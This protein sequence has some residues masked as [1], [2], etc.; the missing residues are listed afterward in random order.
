VGSLV[1]LAARASSFGVVV[2]AVAASTV[3]C[4]DSD[5]KAASAPAPAA[6]DAA[7]SADIGTSAPAGGG[8]G[9]ASDDAGL[10]IINP[11]GSQGTELDAGA[12]VDL[13]AAPVGTCDQCGAARESACETPFAAC[14]DQAACSAVLDCVYVTE[15]CALDSSGAV[16]VR[17]C[18]EAACD[19][20]PSLELFFSA[21]TCAF[22]TELCLSDC[23]GYCSGLAALAAL[24][25]D[26][27]ESTGDELPAGTP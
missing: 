2:L 22:C 24:A 9:G 14:R 19:D 23:S 13:D 16:C 20:P 11:G 15:Q 6:T 12:L 5:G 21:E 1:R 10:L 3:T 26:C 4:V 8:A 18:V 25:P 27:E 17:T 7:G